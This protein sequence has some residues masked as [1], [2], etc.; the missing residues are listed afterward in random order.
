M[1]DEVLTPEQI[2]ALAR[3]WWLLVSLGLLSL[4]AGGVVLAKRPPG[5][6][7]VHR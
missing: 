3:G 5:R 4:V 6:A 1:P 2:R 7:V